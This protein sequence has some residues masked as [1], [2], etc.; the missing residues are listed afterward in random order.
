MIKLFFYPIILV[1]FLSCQKEQSNPDHLPDEYVLVEFAASLED[2]YE[3]LYPEEKKKMPEPP[4]EIP[5]K[6]H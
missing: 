6:S 5:E 1:C 3:K 2:E 4:K